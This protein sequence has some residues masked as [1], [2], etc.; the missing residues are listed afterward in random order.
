MTVQQRQLAVATACALARFHAVE[1]RRVE[2]A[3]PVPRLAQGA[4]EPKFL[5]A[6]PRRRPCPSAASLKRSMRKAAASRRHG[7]RAGAPGDRHRVGDSVTIWSPAC[8]S[9]A[10]TQPPLATVICAWQA[11]RA[12]KRQ[13]WQPAFFFGRP[14]AGRLAITVPDAAAPCT[15]RSHSALTTC[16]WPWPRCQMANVAWRMVC[17]ETGVAGRRR[18][19]GRRLGCSAGC[20]KVPTAGSMRQRC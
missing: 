14:A 18:P 9:Q 12:S 10:C 17:F 5:H 20:F 19:R 6:R 3:T 13:R 15:A 8:R 7:G 11:S 1:A 2:P 4:L 16:Q